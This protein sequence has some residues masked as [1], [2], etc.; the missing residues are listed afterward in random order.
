MYAGGNAT[1][2]FVEEL[3]KIREISKLK[4]MS[5]KMTDE[6]NKIFG[7]SKDCWI[8]EKPFEPGKGKVWDRCHFTGRFFGDA[9]NDC[10]LRFQR[11]KFI[12]VFFHS[13]KN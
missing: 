6:Y 13:L 7:V 1:D 12:P 3:M 5:L 9:H 10:N 4:K 11:I 8:L 2:K